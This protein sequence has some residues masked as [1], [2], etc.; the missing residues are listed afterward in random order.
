MNDTNCFFENIKECS[1]AFQSVQKHWL[2]NP[3]NTLIG[4]LNVNSIRNKLEAA[5]KLVQNKVDT[6]FLSET[7][8]DELFPDQQFMIDKWL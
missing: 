1:N 5:E 6:C 7:K 3:K 8:I 4:H 2:Q